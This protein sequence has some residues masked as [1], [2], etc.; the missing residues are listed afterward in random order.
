MCP[1]GA[2][3]AG[4]KGTRIRSISGDLI[5]KA[6]VPVAG[7]PIVFW[8]LKLFA[9]YGIRE[10]SVIAGHLADLLVAG[11][12]GEAKE[13][14]LSLEYFIEKE[15]LGTAGGLMN[16]KD[17]FCSGDFLV[18]YCDIMVDMNFTR[19][20]DFHQ[21]RKSKATIVSHPNDHPHESDLLSTD[22]QGRIT[23]ILSRNNR[24]AGFYPNLVPAAV[25]CL[26]HEIF[27]FIIPNEKQDFIADVFPRMLKEGK[28]VYAYNTPEYLRDMGTPGRYAMVENDIRQ[29][30]VAAMNSSFR[31]PAV[32]F[33]RD[34]VLVK[35]PGG[36]GVLSHMDLEVLSGAAEAVK[37]VNDSGWLAI[38]ATNQPQVAKGFVSFAEL[39]YIHAKLETL[40]GQGH[41]KLDRIYYCPHHPERGF[42]GEVAE[43]KIDC[44]CRKPKPGL[45]RKA[46]DELPVDVSQSCMIGDSFR[47]VGAARALGLYAYGV[48]TG[49][50]CRDC[51]GA[52]QPDLIF[53]DVLEA[54]NFL[55]AE[56]KQ[57]AVLAEFV[58]E[59][60]KTAVRPF[61]VG[62]CGFSRSG[63]STFAHGIVRELR[64][65]GIGALHVKLD[66]WI[67]PRS[68]RISNPG[69]EERNQASLYP[70]LLEQLLA[71]KEIVGA[72]YWEAD[73][74]ASALVRY[75]FRDERVVLL[76]GLY[77]CHAGIRNKLDWSVYLETEEEVLQSRFREFYR[78]KGD[79]ED[80]V[81]SLLSERIEEEWPSILKQRQG[82]DKVLYFKFHAPGETRK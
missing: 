25:Y 73:R 21:S 50:G 38:A 9:R 60:V 70:L 67:L 13:L 36:M 51:G 48:R 69:S 27:D 16:A 80:T 15:P 23:A 56:Q 40:L 30:K 18:S 29:G 34:G 42:E 72:G 46:V 19:L 58:A 17:F 28:P 8:L 68:K 63:K 76:D 3:I 14:G 1:R 7:Q 12:S 32:F 77:A 75:L 81:E 10:I 6:L 26:N 49:V 54:V 11:M 62:I 71:G 52:F 44:L 57:I 53:A 5:P 66:G 22:K 35:E 33:D 45:L 55:T 79:D 65:K 20:L 74:E 82:A 4:G 41:A 61:V 64:K 24:P 43:L 31:R 47:D 39:D 78:W 2:I 59:S 37:L